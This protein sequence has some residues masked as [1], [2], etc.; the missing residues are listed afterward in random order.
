METPI[1]RSFPLAAKLVLGMAIVLAAAA[2][3]A[4]SVISEREWA[5]LVDAKVHTVEQ[6]AALFAEF[7]AAAVYFGDADTLT[8]D[9]QR[10]RETEGV[11][12]GA[13]WIGDEVA[14]AAELRVANDGPRAPA[15][16]REQG[17]TVSED[18]VTVARLVRNPDG[19]VIGVVRID[20]T[21]EAERASH[22]AA[23]DTIA[24]F[25][26]ILGLSVALLLWTML[27][28]MVTGPLGVL[29]SASGDLAQGK[30]TQ[31]AVRGND[32]VARLGRAFNDMAA[33][34]RDRETR[35]AE[36]SARLQT[37]LDHMGQV[38]LLF[39][40]DGA[41]D[42]SRSRQADAFIGTAR[43]SD[44]SPLLYP[45]GSL[46]IERDAFEMWK[47]AVFR[48]GRADW[49]ELLELAPEEL[50]H[51]TDGRERSYS[52]LFRPVFEGE[53]LQRVLLIA[54]DITAQRDLER[55]VRENERV[56]QN[57]VAA[58]RRLVAGGGQVFVRFLEQTRTRLR[59]IE[60]GIAESTDVPRS[61]VG[62]IFRTMHTLRAEARCFDLEAVGRHAQSIETRLNDLRS[63]K[64]GVVIPVTEMNQ[65]IADLRAALDNAEQLFVAQS[66]VGEAILD[67]D[68]GAP[69]R[70]QHGDVADPDRRARAAQPPRAPGRAPL[71]RAGLPGARGRAALVRASR[72]E[73]PDRHRGPRVRRARV[74]QRCAG[75]CAQP[76]GA[77][78]DRAR[79][80]AARG[81][82]RGGQA[83]DG[84]HPRA[85]RSGGRGCAH[86][87]GGR[88]RGHRR[89]R[90]ARFGRGQ[91]HRRRGRGLGPAGGAGRPHQPRGSR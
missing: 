57:A 40:P 10:L 20:V 67:P 51:T 77:Q 50:A 76:P 58:M 38:I 44:I 3:V 33:A 41:V 47:D 46:D 82:R 26:S 19:E 45:E 61:M 84:H 14:P 80:R 6:I 72:R 32:E 60:S 91:G 35:I 56:H 63:A 64:S 22:Q 21:L 54:T 87:G 48:G 18:L 89:S 74:A 52:L 36:T 75:R 88:R 12:Y 81:A 37:L 29:A 34:I 8:T 5:R 13:V 16:P 85:L 71:R 39:G 31:V 70:P 30:L 4:S 11:V 66:P 2:L 90:P 9:V 43:A 68:H 59:R 1:K 62:E 65:R 73:G 79:H 23:T 53:Q 17:V 7:E 15:P 24:L 78:R 55:S 86:R 49:E 25:A 42:A 27:G 28:R 69:R 83:R